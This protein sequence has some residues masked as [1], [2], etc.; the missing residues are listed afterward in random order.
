MMLQLVPYMTT[1]AFAIHIP[2]FAIHML[3]LIY[4]K[5]LIQS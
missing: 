5:E 3:I 4:K 1:G 2:D